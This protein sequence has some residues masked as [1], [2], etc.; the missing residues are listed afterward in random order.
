MD[1]LFLFLMAFGVGCLSGVALI[2]VV[3]WAR[4]RRA[5]VEGVEQR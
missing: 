3:A 4:A 2:R 1:Q 5:S